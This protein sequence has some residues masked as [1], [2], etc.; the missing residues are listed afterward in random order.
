MESMD[1][2]DVGRIDRQGNGFVL[3]IDTGPI[4]EITYVPHGED[5]WIVDHTFVSPEHR[6]GNMARR[7]LDR[8]VE[9]ARAEGKQIIPACSYALLQFKR[10]PEYADVWKQS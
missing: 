6:G 1:Q 7:L 8:V 4:G 2:A 3:R 10:N 9:E 5:T